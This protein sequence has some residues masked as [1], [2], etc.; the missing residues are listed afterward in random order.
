MCVCCCCIYKN[1]VCFCSTVNAIITPSGNNTIGEEFNLTCTVTSK[2]ASTIVWYAPGDVK[3]PNGVNDTRKVHDVMYTDT[4][5][6]NKIHSSVLLFDPL[7]ASHE[8]IYACSIMV[9]TSTGTKIKQV[10]VKGTYLS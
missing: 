2:E 8:G 6:G 7:Q 10:N 4:T 3:L 9:G 1:H 5:T